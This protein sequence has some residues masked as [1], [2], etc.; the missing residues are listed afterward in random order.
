M[1][2]VKKKGAGYCLGL[3]GSKAFIQQARTLSA[4]AELEAIEFEEHNI[5]ALPEHLGE[6]FD[7]AMI[8]VG[9]LNWMPDLNLFMQACAS[10]LKPEGIL[11]VD[12]IHPI[13][14]MYSE[15][16]P[17]HLGASYF[18]KTPYVDNSGLDYFTNTKYQAKEN[19]WFHHTLS[20]ILMAAIDS[21]LE[22]RSMNEVAENLGNYCADLEHHPCNP[23]LGFVASW[24]KK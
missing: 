17:S 15:G 11:L 5:Y 8:T 22:L 19:Y 24:K 7:I 6:R 12:E 10:L 2:S 1:I 16:K 20:D 18:D 4:V 14:N 21:G 9:V 23:P 13:L 3:D